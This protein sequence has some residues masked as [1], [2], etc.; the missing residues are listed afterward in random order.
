MHRAHD[1][2]RLFEQRDAYED[3][4]DEHLMLLDA[5]SILLADE[6]N[7]VH[8]DWDA[9]L[10]DETL[11]DRFKVAFVEAN[12]T[13]YAPCS[14]AMKI[15]Y[16]QLHEYDGSWVVER[17]FLPASA[18]NRRMSRADGVPLVSAEGH[19]PLTC[20]DVICCSQQMIGDEVNIVDM[21]NSMGLGVTWQQRCDHDPLAI[22]GGASSFNPSVIKD[23]CDLYFIGEGEDILPSLLALVE[24]GMR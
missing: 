17:C 20:F 5:P 15:F 10:H 2:E 24:E 23:V 14:T 1:W 8:F 16:Q 4:L 11:D 18:N 3:W 13:G 22:R 12:A 7:T 9:A 6:T 21:L 19:I